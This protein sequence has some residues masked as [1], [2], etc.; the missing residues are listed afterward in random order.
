MPSLELAL[1]LTPLELVDLQRFAGERGVRFET[2][3]SQWVRERIQQEQERQ[4]QEAREWTAQD[5]QEAIAQLER[6]KTNIYQPK[7]LQA[8][9]KLERIA[10]EK[11][12]P[13]LRAALPFLRPN[14]FMLTLPTEY[15]ALRATIEAATAQWK[16]LPRPAESDDELLDA[17]LPRPV[18]PP[19]V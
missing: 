12:M 9:Y 11:P 16:D 17:D 10:R 5:V 15:A 13:G 4:A 3:I 18:S 19:D 14:W 1:E 7:A 8:L 6:Y 2:L